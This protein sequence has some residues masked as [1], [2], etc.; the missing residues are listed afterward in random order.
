MKRLQNEL[1]T[2]KI[3][4]QFCWKNDSLELDGAT[5]VYWQSG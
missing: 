4:G 5:K 3:A 1:F 2:S